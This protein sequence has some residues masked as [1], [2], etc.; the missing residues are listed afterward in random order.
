MSKQLLIYTRAQ[1][2][3][4]QRHREWSVKSGAS[5]EFAREVNSLPLTAVEFMSSA[6]EYPIVFAGSDD[7]LMPLAVMGVRDKENLFIDAD[8]K[9]DASYVPAFLRRYPFVFSSQDDG[10]N[11]TLCIDETFSGCN[12]ENLGE[13]LFD[14]EGEQTQY[15]KS[16]LEF[17]KE[18]QIHFA[19]TQAFSKKLKDLG[20]LEPMGAQ[21]T[22][23]S[24]EKLTLTGFYAVNR[25]KLKELPSEEL[26]QLV[27]NDGME[28]IYLH[29]HSLRNF[30][31]MLTKIGV[32]KAAVDAP[33][34][35][36]EIV[37]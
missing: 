1:A 12:Q 34:K 3:S 35:E 33:E 21:F 22:P 37:A 18:Y 8:G 29:L 13:R 30:N 14:S 11:F 19:R 23:P 2:V 27:K 17:L 16:V 31:T 28:L 9:L 10:D 4:S 32:E 5:Y 36:A 15:L 25:Q 26:E 20:L 24:G 7:Q 6:A